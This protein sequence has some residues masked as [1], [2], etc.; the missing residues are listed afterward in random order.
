MQHFDERAQDWDNDIEKVERAGTLAKE[1]ID[2]IQP[3][4]SFNALEFGCGTGLLSYQLKNVFKSIT[5]VD[6]SEG[7]MKVLREKIEREK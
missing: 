2:F 3:D 7:M 1:I 5:L 6:T 4:K